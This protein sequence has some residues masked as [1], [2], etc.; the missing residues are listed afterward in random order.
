MREIEELLLTEALQTT[1]YISLHGDLGR[2][3]EGVLKVNGKAVPI[4]STDFL[5][6]Y[7]LCSHRK[8]AISTKAKPY[9]TTEELRSAMQTIKES[10]AERPSG[11]EGKS[12]DGRQDEEDLKMLTVESVRRSVC[13]LRADTKGLIPGDPEWIETAG[14]RGKGYR[15]STL[16][17]HVDLLVTVAPGLQ[18]TIDGLALWNAPREEVDDDAPDERETSGRG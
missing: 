7:L 1:A 6:L 13:D 18:R 16:A 11:A 5:L 8:R 15:L 14:S 17:A 4:S 2:P 10:I 3:K 12:R 9:L